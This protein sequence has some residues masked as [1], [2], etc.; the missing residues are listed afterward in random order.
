[1]LAFSQESLEVSICHAIRQQRRVSVSHRGRERVVEPY[2][3][4]ETKDGG[5]TLHAWQVSGQW[6]KTPPPDWCDISLA[7]VE[8]V[9]LLGER[10]EQPNPGYSPE[11]DRFHRVI[12]KV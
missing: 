6:S 2:L 4:F 5:M 9:E 7:D 8:W 10:F 1:M 11:S 12:C 3:L